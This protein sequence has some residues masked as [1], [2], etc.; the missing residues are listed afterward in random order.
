MKYINAQ[1]RMVFREELTNLPSREITSYDQLS[2]LSEGAE[3][4]IMHNC[5]M[6]LGTISRCADLIMVRDGV[7]HITVR[8]DSF[9]YG[10]FMH[11]ILK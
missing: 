9:Q 6:L 4:A 2:K 8:P 7:E 1:R 10:N 11:E 5:S 3:V